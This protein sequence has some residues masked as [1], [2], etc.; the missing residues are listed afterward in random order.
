MSDE[1]KDCPSCNSEF[2]YALG[3]GLFAQVAVLNGSLK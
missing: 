3:N 1:L 2:A